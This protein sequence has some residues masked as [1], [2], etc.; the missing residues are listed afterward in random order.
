[1]SSGRLTSPPKDAET[2]LLLAAEDVSSR[3]TMVHR[4]YCTTERSS[5]ISKTAIALLA[6]AIE[7]FKRERK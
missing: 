1:M 3:L 7:N 6:L 4:V 5:E 2:E